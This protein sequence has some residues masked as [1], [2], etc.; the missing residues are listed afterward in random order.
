M[1]ILAESNV[2]SDYSFCSCRCNVIP[3]GR[4]WPFATCL[5]LLLALSFARLHRSNIEIGIPKYFKSHGLVIMVGVEFV[6]HTL[7][8]NKI[9]HNL[10][11]E[12]KSSTQSKQELLES[13]PAS[14]SNSLIDR[15]NPEVNR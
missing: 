3:L 14:L 9:T 13:V 10:N 7:N 8:S 12:D 11:L 6:L 15:C 4:F 5:A 2:S 1:L